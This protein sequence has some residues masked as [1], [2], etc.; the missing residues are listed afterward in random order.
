[1]NDLKYNYPDEPTESGLAAASRA[2]AA[3]LARGRRTLSRRHAR[4][5]RER[6]SG[7]SS[8]PSRELNYARYFL[9]VHDIVKFARSQSASSAR[10]AARPPI[11][12]SAIASASPMSDP[13]LID[14]LFERFISKERNE[15]P[16]I[17]VDFEHEKR[18]EVIAYIYR[19]IQREA[20]RARRV[21]HHLSR[22]LGAARG[23]QGDGPVGRCAQRACPA[24]SGAGR[25]RE[26]ASK[27]AKAAG[28]DRTDPV[29]RHVLDRANEIMGSPR[30][31]SQHVGGFV[32]TRDRLDEIVPIVKTAMDER[33]MVE[34]DKDD[35]DAVGILKVDVLA[36]GM[37]S[38]LRRAFDLLA[39]HYHVTDPHG[40]PLELA[41]IPPER[42]TV[43]DMICRADTLGVFQIESA[44]PDV[45]CCRGSSR[46]NSTTSSSRWRSCGP[47]RSRATWCI[48]ICAAGRAR[49]SRNIRSRS[50]KRSSARRSACRC[51][52]SRRCGSPSRPAAS[53]PARPTSCAAPWRPSSAPAPSATTA[54][55]MIEGMVAARLRAGL[56]RTLLQADRR[57]RRIRLSRKPCR[58]LRAAG[59]CLLLVQDLL[60]RRL[61]RGDPELPA[62]GLLPAGAAGARRPATT[63]SRSATVDVNLPTGIARWRQAPSTRAASLDGMPKCAASSGPGTPSGSASGRSRG[64]PKSACELFVARRGA[65]Y[66]SVRDVWL[67]SGLA[68]GEIERLAAGRRLPLARPRPARRAVGGAR[69]RR[70]ECRRAAAAV[71]PAELRAC[72][73][74]SRR[75]SCPRMPLGEHVIHDYRSLGLSLKAHPVAF[76]RQRLD[77]RRRH[78]ECRLPSV[79]DGSRVSVAG[80]VLVRQRPGN[81]NAIFLTLED[82]KARRQHHRLAEDVRALPAD[83]HRRPL[84]PGHAASC[85]R[86]RASS[87]SS[88]RGSKT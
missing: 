81:G 45:A 23:R 19:E 48:P 67:R 8:R 53:R 15:P 4:Q 64:C 84:R 21:G 63:A 42:T 74:M 57:V 65:G 46:A 12:S 20:H 71:R 34:W 35:L 6:S 33:K 29:I 32:I 52:R 51:S 76:L 25:H 68:V 79:R 85:S 66:D 60:S 62:D 59:L 47:A 61:L 56:R 31:L 10:A 30:H 14:T 88:P 40:R 26:S 16:D 87:I 41:T 7:T 75:R 44:R 37:L 70:Q 73:T 43:Y 77:A 22:P 54:S 49:R 9:T 17:D 28:L 86:N 39:D 50:W 3:D 82:E 11:P 83:R 58:L 1:M 13:D 78:A 5:G 36:L 55:E 38:C 27:E 80:L 2:G 72:A 24:R 18:D 69:A